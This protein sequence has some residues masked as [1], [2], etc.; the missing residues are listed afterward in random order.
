MIAQQKHDAVVNMFQCLSNVDV[1]VVAADAGK[2][3]FSM[4]VIPVGCFMIRMNHR[5]NHIK[6]IIKIFFR[7]EIF[8]IFSAGHYVVNSG[9]DDRNLHQELPDF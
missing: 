7:K 2:Q 4:A 5:R 8:Y 1:Y 9:A 3:V 6:W